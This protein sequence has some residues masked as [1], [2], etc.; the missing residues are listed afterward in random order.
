MYFA[1]EPEKLAKNLNVHV[2][3]GSTPFPKN[4]GKFLNR[5]L[6]IDKQGLVVSYY[7]KINYGANICNLYI[8]MD[9]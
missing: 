4:D 8:F 1:I 2:L 6:I 9:C 7:D 5:S 3:V